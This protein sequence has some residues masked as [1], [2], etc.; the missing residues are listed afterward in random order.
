MHPSRAPSG[1]SDVKANLHVVQGGRIDLLPRS[2]L[3]CTTASTPESHDGEAMRNLSGTEV[4]D[5]GLTTGRVS[6]TTS[7][8]LVGACLDAEQGGVR[9]CLILQREVGSPEEQGL[10]SMRRRKQ[11]CASCAQHRVEECWGHN[12]RIVARRKNLGV[13]GLV[14]GELDCC[15]SPLTWRH[16][17]AIWMRRTWSE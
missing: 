1:S 14:M 15:L 6:T 13:A 2:P 10:A 8:C 9:H 11:S 7:S 4:L 17:G 3:S 12:P 16:V 5:V